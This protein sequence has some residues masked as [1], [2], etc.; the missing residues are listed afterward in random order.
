MVNH[1]P[2]GTDGAE[3][4]HHSGRPARALEIAFRVIPTY[5]L[6]AALDLA[7]AG[8]ASLARAW[9]NLAVLAGSVIVAFAVVVWTLGREEK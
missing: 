1:R 5:H 7:L 3:L 8:K 9:G 2:L 6:S 4:V